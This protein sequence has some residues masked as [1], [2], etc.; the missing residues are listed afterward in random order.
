MTIICRYEIFSQISFKTNKIRHRSMGMKD[1]VTMNAMKVF[2][3]KV[4][5]STDHEH[6][7]RTLVVL[8]LNFFKL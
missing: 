7:C 6:E 5:A 3:V 4:K 2:Q 8:P 1:E